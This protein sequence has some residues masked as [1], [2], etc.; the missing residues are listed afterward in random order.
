M[1]HTE[2]KRRS[3]TT[4]QSDSFAQ[5]VWFALANDENMRDQDV[6]LDGRLNSI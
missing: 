4:I 6:Q 3:T 1:Q 5:S 2:K